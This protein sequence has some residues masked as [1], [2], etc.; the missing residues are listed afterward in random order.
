MDEPSTTLWGSDDPGVIT[1]WEQWGNTIGWADVCP[2]GSEPGII[3]KDGVEYPACLST[4]IFY[5]PPFLPPALLE[6]AWPE[7]WGVLPPG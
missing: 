5:A 4:G 7:D 1:S 3:E 6:L 2:D